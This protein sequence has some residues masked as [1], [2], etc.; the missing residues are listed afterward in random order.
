MLSE[1]EMRT[2]AMNII[3]FAREDDKLLEKVAKMTEK[4]RSK[5]QRFVTAKT[6]ASMLGISTWT[7]YRLK[8]YPSGEPVFTSIKSGS[9][10]SSTLKYDASKLVQEYEAYLAWKR[11]STAQ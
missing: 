11:D 1:A 8:T 6:A 3:K 9:S 7:L 2:I 4:L 10:R 5:Q